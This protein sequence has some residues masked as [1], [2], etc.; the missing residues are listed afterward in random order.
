[1]W[2]LPDGD[3]AHDPPKSNQPP[4]F[5]SWFFSLA[6]RFLLNV[7]LFLFVCLFANVCS[8][9][10]GSR[11]PSASQTLVAQQKFGFILLKSFVQ[12]SKNRVTVS[13]EKVSVCIFTKLKNDGNSWLFMLKHRGAETTSIHES[14][15]DTSMIY[16]SFLWSSYSHH[17]FLHLILL[18]GCYRR[19][20]QCRRVVVVQNLSTNRRKRGNDSGPK[21]T[22]T[23]GW[24]S[25]GF[26]SYCKWV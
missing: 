21:P 6:V 1:M 22:W 2:F 4:V 16:L 3:S 23:G 25:L 24:R 5:L 20:S 19:W 26:F 8:P 13:L 7:F 14:N 10:A 18:Y 17:P 15:Q 11:I 12:T 9:A